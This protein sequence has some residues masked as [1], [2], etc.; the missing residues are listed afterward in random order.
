MTLQ[1][2]TTISA[3]FY[4]IKSILTQ[5]T[6]DLIYDPHSSRFVAQTRRFGRLTWMVWAARTRSYQAVVHCASYVGFKTN[7]S[8]YLGLV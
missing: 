2:S 6:L 4:Y 5:L 3:F 1:R 8:N 7:A